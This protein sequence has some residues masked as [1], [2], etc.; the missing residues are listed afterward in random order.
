MRAERV[1]PA[2]K[3]LRLH[4]NGKIRLDYLLRP[5]A[6]RKLVEGA[7]CYV[8]NLRLSPQQVMAVWIGAAGGFA[9]D[10]HGQVLSASRQRPAAE[11]TSGSRPAKPLVLPRGRPAA[12]RRARRP[13]HHRPAG[14]G[15]PS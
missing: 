13:S 8:Q 11:T 2:H 7:V 12:D 15:P 1:P 6:A 5:E 10:T 9:R 4:K 14:H 3:E